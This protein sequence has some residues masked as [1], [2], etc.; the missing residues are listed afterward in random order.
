MKKCLSL[1]VSAA[2]AASVSASPVDITVGDG[3]LDKM[4]GPGYLPGMEDQNLNFSST[5]GDEWDLEAF[6]FDYGTAKLSMVSGFNV[7]ATHPE[8]VLL[9]DIFIK[10]AGYD[11]WKYA[12]TFNRDYGAD[13]FTNYNYT[14]VDL[15]VAQDVSISKGIMPDRKSGAQPYALKSYTG[16]I[17][18]QGTFIYKSYDDYN[19]LLGSEHFLM[20]GIDLKKIYKSGQYYAFHQTMSCGNDVL[21]G[22]VPEPAMLSLLGLGMMGLAFFRK[23]KN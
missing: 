4:T 6:Y 18:D 17:V 19:G 21:H 23:R 12:I 13:V 15:A 3:L 14:I 5:W 7:D 9:G 8:G 2:F 22:N 16:G 10:T 1:M 11:S 20:S